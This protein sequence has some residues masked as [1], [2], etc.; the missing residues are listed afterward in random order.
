MP[1][2][3]NNSNTSNSMLELSFVWYPDSGTN[4]HVTADLL[5]VNMSYEYKGKDKLTIGNGTRLPISHCGSRSMKILA[6]SLLLDNVS[7]VPQITKL[8]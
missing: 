3:T 8:L 6:E 1:S 2:P 4:H 7:R 5:S